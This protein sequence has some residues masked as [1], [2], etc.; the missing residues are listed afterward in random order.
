MRAALQQSNP[1]PNPT[2]R[3]TNNLD[4]PHGSTKDVPSKHRPRQVDASPVR[5]EDAWLDLKL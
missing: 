3:Q 2:K 1:Q 4:L 5:L